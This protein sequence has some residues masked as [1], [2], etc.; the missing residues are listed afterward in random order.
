MKHYIGIDLGTTNSAVSAYDGEIVRLFKS[1]DQNDVTPS[2]IFIDRRGNKYV[3]RRAYDN[4]ARN[5]ENAATLF[6]RLMGTSTP[7][8]LPAVDLTLTPEECSAE[9]LRVLFGYLPEDVRNDPDIGTVIT[10]PAAFNQ[11][12]KD[13]TMAAAEMAGMGK[14]ALMQ[15]PVAAVMS[16]MRL[17]KDDGT[18]LIYDLGGGT[19]DIAI[20]ESINGRVSLLAHGGI[21]MCGGRD[22]DRILL[23]SVVKPW[24]LENFDL[25][26]DFY[27][28]ARYTTLRHMATWAAEKAKIEL[29]S[30]DEAVVTLDDSELRVRDEAGVDIYLDISLSRLRY[31]EL[32]SAKIEESI[33]AARETIEKAGLNA[34]DIGRV[35]FVGGPTQYKPLRDKVAVEL[36][37]AAS[38]DVNPM[39]AV[40]EG[41]AV[42]AESIDWSSQN[43]GRKSG[44]GALS[45]GGGLDLA[46]NYQAR[47]PDSKAK[48][49]ARIGS[50]VDDGVEFQVDSLDT[51]WSSGRVALTDGASVDVPLAKPGENLFK[52]FVFDAAG[53]PVK[54]MKD[55]IVISRT[56]AQIDAIPA[57]HSIGVEA[58]EKVGGRMILDY[59]VR[60]GDQ[61]P[62]IGKKTFKAEESLIAGAG[63]SIKF[64][65]WEGSIEDPVS[66]NRFIGMFEI[67]G[68]D[69]SAGVIAKGAELQCAYEVLDSGN[70]VLEVTVPSIGNSFSSGRNFYSRQ[71]GQIDYSK[72]TE[73]LTEE[74]E[75]IGNRLDEVESKIDDP[76]IAQARERLRRASVAK[77]LE[78]DP[79]TAKQAMDDIQEAKKL[80]ALVRKEHIKVI[81]QMELD[82]AIENFELRFRLMARPSETVDFENLFKAAQRAIDNN[83]GDFDLHLSELNGK[84]FLILWRQDWFVIDRF[85]Q[86]SRNVFLFPDTVEHE[87]LCQMGQLAL[88]ANDINKLRQVVARLDSI[89]VGTSG[90]DDIIAS[91]NI[92]VS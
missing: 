61:L 19:L 72:A 29:S 32:I 53:G 14:V 73:R 43:R 91:S 85:Q 59:L 12:Q 8:K 63:G 15:E 77:D 3:G 79:E 27:S 67:R 26:A 24:L 89:R 51:G 80:L 62:K 41:A 30:S 1:P 86:L 71:E 45:T 7:V 44:R 68:S 40:A 38:T 76:R 55:R 13:A 22:F 57:S 16:V 46:F 48:V 5:P 54:L 34:G 52:V 9:I 49:V 82:K 39:T 11:M 33:A 28:D 18:F 10:V 90:E 36:G 4:A 66:D 87:Q 47:T 35:V 60:D 23:D 17:R 92:V 21:A 74:L 25:P 65:L 83:R 56:A 84:S 37:I 75:Q 20:A 88:K 2:A 6:K 69:F 64:K 81:R 78:G 58:R 50:K 42:F 70:I 31:D